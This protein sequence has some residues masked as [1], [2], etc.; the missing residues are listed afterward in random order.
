MNPLR[1]LRDILKGRGERKACRVVSVSASTITVASDRGAV[2]LP[3]TDATV[4]AVGDTVVLRGGV[5]QGRVR[6]ERDL[7]TFVL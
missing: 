3:R 6:D 5:L 1:D 2:V 7:P 4:Y